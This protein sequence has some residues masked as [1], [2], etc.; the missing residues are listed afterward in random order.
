MTDYFLRA[1][2]IFALLACTAGPVQAAT[3]AQT[4]EMPHACV[5]EWTPHYSCKIETQPTTI[6]V[7][8]YGIHYGGNLVYNYKVVNNGD[9]PFHYFTIGSEF[10]SAQD[11]VNMDDE[12]PQLTRLP[13]GWKF[14][15]SGAEGT[16]IVLAPGSTSQPP[17]WTSSV[18]GQ[19]ETDN[20]YLNWLCDVSDDCDILPGQ[21]LGGFSV[22]VPLK[23]SNISFPASTGQPVY[24]GPDEMYV[25]GGSRLG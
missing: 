11:S 4:S 10:N 13:L 8:V 16:E 24:T 5:E 19:Q 22:T 2:I 17:N 3:Y 6:H 9:T 20:Y 21:T 7:L 25:K 15:E 18:F 1:A 23:D 12:F 14:G